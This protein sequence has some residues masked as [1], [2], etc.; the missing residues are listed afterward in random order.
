MLKINS[1]GWQNYIAGIEK[2]FS[3]KCRSITSLTDI[4]KKSHDYFAENGC[5]SSDH[6]VET[7]YPGTADRAYADRAF[8]KGLEG[9]S[10]T[11]EEA[12][13]FADYLFGEMGEF[14]AEKNW[15][16]QLHIG[17]VRDVRRKLFE[18]IGPDSGGDVS[19]H[20]IDILPPLAAFLNRFDGRLKVVLYC[21]DAA[22]QATLA[23][24]ARA[25]GSNVRL[26][27]AWW[28]CDNPV[29]MKRQLEDIGSVDLLSCFAG[30]GSDSRKILSYG[31]RFEMFRRVLCDVLGEMT[32]KGQIPEDVAAQLARK[33]CYDS[34]KSFFNL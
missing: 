22:H 17:A 18:N 25:F 11:P 21:L 12:G 30:M 16:F 13:I 28:F 29:G 34:P 10:V 33:I 32:E 24:V 8:R 2:R 19:N 15:V 7:P 3:I 23:T 14:D 31:S 1:A 5:V 6:G 9:E 27:S 4:L 26:G 20:F